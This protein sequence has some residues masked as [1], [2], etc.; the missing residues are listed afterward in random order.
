M[1]HADV[2]RWLHRIEAEYTEMP[3]LNLTRAQ[4]RRLF[5]LEAAVCDTLLDALVAARVLRES[6]AGTY[7][8]HESAR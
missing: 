7:V 4:M 8:A 2:S 1:I 6:A 5:D 3:G